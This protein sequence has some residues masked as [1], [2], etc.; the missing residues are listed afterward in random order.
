VNDELKPCPFCG[1]TP[2]L[3]HDGITGAWYRGECTQYCEGHATVMWGDRDAVIASWNTRPIEDELRARWD[4]IPWAALYDPS[5][6]DNRLDIE[7]WYDANAPRQR[8]TDEQAAALV[9][10][11]RRA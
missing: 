5:A 9:E 6:A 10:L 2:K 4:A 3:M 1:I 11:I 7:R 8:M